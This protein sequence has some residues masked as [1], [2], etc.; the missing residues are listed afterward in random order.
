MKLFLKYRNFVSMESFRTLTDVFISFSTFSTLKFVALQIIFCLSFFLVFCGS[1][2]KDFKS[3]ERFFP[4]IT[5]FL[6]KLCNHI[7]KNE[8]FSQTFRTMHTSTIKYFYLSQGTSLNWIKFKI[9][10][11]W[12]KI[13]STSIRTYASHKTYFMVTQEIV[14]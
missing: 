13:K 7:W 5:K 6:Y 2:R 3:W 9:G 10:G 8:T 1:A 11:K 12:R 4:P 14:T